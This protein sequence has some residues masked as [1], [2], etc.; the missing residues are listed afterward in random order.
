MSYLSI[1]VFVM[2]ILATPCTTS[3]L[4]IVEEMLEFLDPNFI[5][6]VLPAISCKYEFCNWIFYLCTSLHY[7]CI[8][9]TC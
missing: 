2:G 6:L 3:C 4:C 1:S 9:Y 5:S 7:F 8:K